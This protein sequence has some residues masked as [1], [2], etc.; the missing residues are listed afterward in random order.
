MN[1]AAPVIR[2]ALQTRQTG[3]KQIAKKRTASAVRFF[4]LRRHITSGTG[5]ESVRTQLKHPDA[6]RGSPE[7][8]SKAQNC[9]KTG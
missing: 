9:P 1:A 3:S 4:M 8:L 7:M 2:Q 5:A 6:V